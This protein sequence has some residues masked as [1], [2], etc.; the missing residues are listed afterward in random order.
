[1][2]TVS[3]NST[4]SHASSALFLSI[5]TPRLHINLTPTPATLNQI[6]N[7]HFSSSLSESKQTVMKLSLFLSLASLLPALVS[8][9]PLSLFDHPAQPQHPLR[10]DR[11]VR[12]SRVQQG[13]RPVESVLVH[14]VDPAS[15]TTSTVVTPSSI[16]REALDYDPSS[17]SSEEEI[18]A[19]PNF[20]VRC[21]FIRGNPFTICGDYFDESSQTDHGL[22]CSPSGVCAGKGAVC[23]T[24]DAC[25]EGLV[26]NLSN[27]RCESSTAISK[28]ISESRKHMRQRTAMTM[29]PEQAQACSSDFGGFECVFTES[30]VTQ[31]GGCLGLGGMDCSKIPNSLATS[32]RKGSCKIHA[33]VTGYLPSE[34]GK[35]CI[36]EMLI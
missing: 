13:G 19:S 3:E 6:I 16:A 8:T 18:D 30:E 17:S 9:S 4:L 24:S 10:L 33:C 2:F 31:C 32:C 15:P 27:H 22:F 34:D 28:T 23:G 25:S 26:C 1:M 11:I 29:C 20:G 21:E 5:S 7:R 36:D 14:L 12:P 35:E